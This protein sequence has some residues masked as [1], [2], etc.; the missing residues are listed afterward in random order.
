MTYLNQHFEIEFK[1]ELNKEQY[2]HLLD[3]EFKDSSDN[4][5]NTFQTNYYFDTIDQVL[6][7]Q[8][9]VLR[10]RVTDSSNELTFK[11][12]HQDFL[13]E[14]NYHLSNN[15]CSD[16]IQSTQLVL[17][18]YLLPTDSIPKLENI[19]KDTV[20]R[21]FN[22]FDTDRHEKSVGDHLIVLDMTTFQNGVVDYELEVES[23]SPEAGLDFFN[24]FLEKHAIKK[25]KA[26]PKIAR[27]QQN[28]LEL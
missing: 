13:M 19:S 5:L 20:F 27:A 26:L 3:N 10:I 6:K 23:Q 11:V 7:K 21:L 24:S 8:H 25:Q 16:I 9:S 2:L 1:N 22:Q 15:D 14:S 18:S 12:P 17:S 28:I 4:I